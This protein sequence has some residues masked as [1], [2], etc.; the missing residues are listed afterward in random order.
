MMASPAH[1]SPS[2]EPQSLACGAAMTNLLRKL[3]RRP[4]FRLRLRTFLVL[5]IALGMLGGVV[6]D[7]AMAVMRTCRAVWFLE[8]NGVRVGSD[9]YAR[10]GLFPWIRRGTC[11]SV[12][13][14]S[15]SQPEDA[16]ALGLSPQQTARALSHLGTLPSIR[17]LDLTNCEITSADLRSLR[18]SAGLHELYLGATRIDDSAFQTLTKMRELQTLDLTETQVT[19]SAVA[20]IAG[21]PS[22]KYVNVTDTAISKKAIRELRKIRPDLAVSPQPTKGDR[23][24]AGQ[25]ARGREGRRAKLRAL[26]S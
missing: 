12:L 26:Q 14:W 20:L 4:R 15:V 24:R 8:Q 17:R 1:F 23:A 3:C 25:R 16:L 2:I 22:L 21:M 19:D 13:E 5:C 6:A 11:S 7:R 18:T 9:F 10:Y